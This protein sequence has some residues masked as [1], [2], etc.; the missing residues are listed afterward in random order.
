M[1]TY[2]GSLVQLYCEE[3]GTLQTNI[4]DIVGSVR[5]GWTILGLTHSWQRV[6]SRSTLLRRQVAL[7]G[8]CSKW[9]LGCVHFPGLSC[10]CS[11][12]Q[13][14]HKGTDSIGPA[15]CAR[16]LCLSEF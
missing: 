5:S 2:L 8:N 7:K 16:V 10:S 13:V 12:S 6:L 4:T 14:L 15:F 9:A 1:V 11:G 3:G